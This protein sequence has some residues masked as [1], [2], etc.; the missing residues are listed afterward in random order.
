M[1]R[2]RC[3]SHWGRS[4]RRQGRLAL[5]ALLLSM[6]TPTL[7]AAPQPNI[8]FLLADDLDQLSMQALSTVSRMSDLGVTFTRAYVTSPLCSPSRAGILTGRYPQNTGVLRNKPPFGGFES[9]YANGH[10]SRTIAVSLQAAGY[11]TGFVGKYFNQFPRTA[12][13][14]Y[15]PPG[16]DYWVAPKGG[17]HIHRYFDYELNE[18]GR[19]VGYGTAPGDY[20]MDVYAAK[21][22]AFVEDAAGRGQPFALFLWLPAPHTPEIPAPRHARHFADAKLP[23]NVALPE[24]YIGDKP[25]FL[26]FPPP[27]ADR[28]PALDESY[29]ARLQ[30]LASVNETVGELRRQLAERGQ[31]WRTYFVVASDNGWHQGYHNLTPWKGTG[32]EQDIRVPLVVT[33]PGVPPGRRIDRLVSGADLAPTLAAWTGAAAPAGVDGRSL[34]GLIA[35]PDPRSFPWRKRL[36]F[37]RLTETVEGPAET[38]QRYPRRA[39]ATKS[40]ECLSHVPPWTEVGTDPVNLPEFRGVR[41]ERYTYVEYVTGDLELYDNERSPQQEHNGVCAASSA[42][43]ADLQEQAVGLATCRGAACR[44]I[45]DR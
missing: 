11:R 8:V 43:L 32:Y 40:Y 44:A 35:A 20:A 27:T 19:I 39:G 14:G 30:M 16:W 31:L 37:Y 4:V 22:K 28:L 5:T 26:R 42:L 33:G 38:W 41:T 7:Q 6:A 25:S 10:E 9:F 29:R 2:F 21:A 17:N 23:R 36:P 12:P 3:W 13:S 15:I 18:N 34:A 45:E 1:D 24:W